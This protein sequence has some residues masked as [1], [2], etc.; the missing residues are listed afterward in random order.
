M[1]RSSHLLVVALCCVRCFV[2]GQATLES[3]VETK[4]FFVPGQGEQLD[5]NIN[6]LGGSAVWKANE[7]GA[8]QARV[9]A[10]TIVEQ[11]GNIVDYRKTDVSGPER[12][13]TTRV[14]F[15]H[16][17]HFLLKPGEYSLSVELQDLQG[18]QG[19]SS[20]WSAPLVVPQ[21]PDGIS[22]SDVLLALPTAD[23]AKKEAPMPYAG[24]YYPADVKALSF[25][26]EI[27]GTDKKLGTD[28]LFS[29]SYQ[30]ETYETHQVK[31]SFK[32]VQRMK[33]APVVP[34]GAE[35]PIGEL[36]SGNYVLAVEARDR[37]GELLLRQEQFIQRNNPL[38]YDMNAVASADVSATFVDAMNDPDTLA[39]HISSLRPIA[40]ELERRM[41][42]DR[43]KDK[44]VKLMKRFL[45]TFWYNRDGFDP[46]GAWE[47]YRQQVIIANRLYGCRNKRGYQSD[48]GYVFLKYGSASTIT[49]RSNDPEVK[50]YII[51]HYYRAG[52]YSD[53]RFIFW[54]PDMA[55]NCWELLHSEVPGEVKNPHWNQMLNEATNGPWNVTDPN[56]VNTQEGERIEDNFN[57]PH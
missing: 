41:I 52:K 1:T 15:L 8:R 2:H 50:P 11:N 47:R 5:V 43:W 13:D 39:E 34:V 35:F 45:Y 9:E 30:V 4:R 46:A 23:A 40:N 44:D 20:K 36:P 57:H 6:V 7:R 21:R 10:L 54:Q 18:A 12:N 19:N 31:G 25:Y 26:S 29:V 24:T 53:K 49:D 48:R 28:S 42:D 14:D 51:W 3:V 33:A 17:E 27:Y 38:A 56:K 32:H 16:Q 22:G 37:K 55:G